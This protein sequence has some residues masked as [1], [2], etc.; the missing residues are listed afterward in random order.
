[1]PSMG[2]HTYGGA[3]CTLACMRD[4]GGSG[5]GGWRL[6]GSC[7]R[8]SP[9]EGPRPSAQALAAS[10]YC[11]DDVLPCRVYTRHCVLAAQ[12]LGPSVH[13]NFL[14]ATVLADRS[15]TLRVHLERNPGILEE[16]PPPSLH[17]RYGW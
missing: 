13:E 15:T 7:P 11:R 6:P 2:S 16:L 4:G 9:E 1:M 3:L 8:S 10:P 17:E 12:S 5:D 14:D